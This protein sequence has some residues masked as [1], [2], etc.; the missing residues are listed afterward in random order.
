MLWMSM[1]L[2]QR[3]PNA[4]FEVLK[5]TIARRAQSLL[6]VGSD[7]GFVHELGIVEE[8]LW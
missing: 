5:H 1:F 2:A 4:A 6:S 8:A 3:G 7:E